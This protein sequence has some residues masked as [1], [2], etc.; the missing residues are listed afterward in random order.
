MTAASGLYNVVRQV[1]GSVGVAL[2]ATRLTTATTQY[3][4][5]LAEHVTA[6]DPMAGPWLGGIAH[7]LAQTEGASADIASRQALA[8]LDLRVLRQASVLAYNH[9]FVMVAGLFVISVPMVFLLRTRRHG[10]GHGVSFE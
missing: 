3:H 9:I 4:A 10:G 2:A 7:S 8:L 6:G 1:F 5:E